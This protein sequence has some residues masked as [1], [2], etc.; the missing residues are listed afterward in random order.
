MLNL[1]LS[2]CVGGVN[3]IYGYVAVV[4]SVGFPNAYVSCLC[5]N[6][7]LC[8]VLIHLGEDLLGNNYTVCNEDQLELVC[9]GINCVYDNIACGESVGFPFTGVIIL[10]GNRGSDNV[11]VLNGIV[12]GCNGNTVCNKGN[13]IGDGSVDCVNY[14]VALSENVRFPLA[15]VT[16]LCR[17][18]GNGNIHIIRGVGLGLTNRNTVSLKD[19]LEGEIKLN[20]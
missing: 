9:F 16:F 5:G 8:Y 2:I 12:E 1:V 13:G 10:C 11:L 3:R 4:E 18:L 17:N 19:N 15:G 14:H 20:A 6:I 7:G